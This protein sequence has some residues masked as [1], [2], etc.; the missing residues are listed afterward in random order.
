MLPSIKITLQ[1]VFTLYKNT[2][3]DVLPFVLLAVIADSFFNR[4]I[5]IEESTPLQETVSHIVLQ[6]LV[7]SF[8]FCCVI[9]GIFLKHHQQN[10]N[11]IE[12]IKKGI[13]RVFP[14]IFAGIIVILPLILIFG[15]IV[16]VSA[17]I[18]PEGSANTSNIAKSILLIIYFLGLTFAFLYMLIVFVYCYFVGVFTICKN[19]SSW[20]GIKQSRFLVQNHWGYV[21]VRIL[22]LVMILLIPSFLLYHFLN[23]NMAEAIITFFTFSLGPCMMLI[24]HENLEDKVNNAV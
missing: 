20:Q 7:T 17:F 22:V 6:S 10:F 14:F 1:R 15:V 4:F 9:Y 13:L 12:I 3:I 8:L 16:V 24:L 18:F 5:P 21:F 11:Y 19:T 2:F 23:E